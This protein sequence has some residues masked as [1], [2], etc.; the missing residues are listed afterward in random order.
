VTL[1]RK[2]NAMRRQ[3]QEKRSK[4]LADIHGLAMTE[5][6]LALPILLALAISF[7]ELANY[8]HAHMR[9]SQIALSVADNTGRITQT[10]DITDVDAAMIGAR[11]AGENIKFGQNGRVILSMIERNGQ[12]GTNAGQKITWQRCF[13]LRN[14]SSSYGLVDAGKN[15]ATYAAGFGP[16]GRKIKSASADDGVMFVEVAYDYVPIFPVGQTLIN[17]LRGERISAIAAYPVR[18][19]SNN[20]LLNGFNKAANAP[21]QRLCSAFSA[22]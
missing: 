21:E 3:K 10:I 2:D 12:S 14:I 22:T 13:G 6:A 8:A 11:I 19:R 18:E 20:A 1:V 5:F 7:I 9:V 17:G 16:T 15:D 4:L